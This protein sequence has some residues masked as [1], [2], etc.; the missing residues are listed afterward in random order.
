M[1]KIPFDRC[2]I[3]TTLDFEQIS[4][5][6]ATAIYDPRFSADRSAERAP[7][8]QYYCGQI[9]GFK[10]SASRLIGHKYFHLPL[11]LSPTIEGN[12]NALSTGYEISLTAKLQNVTVVLLLTWLG[13]TAERKCE[14]LWK[15]FTQYPGWATCEKSRHRCYSL[16]HHAR[17]FLFCILAHY[18]IFQSIIYQWTDRGE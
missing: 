6:L 2:V 10:F 12:I 8:H 13:W 14:R 17:L 3:L 16:S 5:R 7:K 11:V 4:E 1:I 9:H 15:S 18:Q